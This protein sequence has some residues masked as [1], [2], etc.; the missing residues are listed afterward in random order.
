MQMVTRFP[1]GARVD[2]EFGPF[3]L[4][5]DQPPHA[6]GEGLAPTPFATFLAVIAAC[7]GAYV[8]AFCRKRG[9]PAEDIRIV[10]NTEADPVTGMVVRVHLDVQLP[11][12]FP[13]KYREPLVRA[14]EQCT[15][16][17]HLES[18][19]R[20]EIETIVNPPLALSTAAGNGE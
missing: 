19:P 17:K 5:T 3:T 15:I 7:A 10:G 11:A 6:G 8:L 9:L 16:K 18:P 13:D 2:T 4:R 20:I 14:A 12:G 1:G